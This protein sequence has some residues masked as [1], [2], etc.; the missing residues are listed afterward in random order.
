MTT[1]SEQY[2]GKYRIIRTL[3][4][5]AM[6]AVYECAHDAIERRFALK[7]LHTSLAADAELTSRFF[8]EARAQKSASDS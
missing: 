4:Q 8:N 1:Q 3:G 7:V 5:G 2:I 6:G